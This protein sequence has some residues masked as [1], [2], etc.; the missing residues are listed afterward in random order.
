MGACRG[1]QRVGPPHRL[2]HEDIIAQPLWSLDPLTERVAPRGLAGRLDQRIERVAGYAERHRRPLRGEHERKRV[3]RSRP[4]DQLRI[5]EAEALFGWNE[6]VVNGNIVAAGAAQ[7]CRIP[8][9]KD[10]AL[11]EAQQ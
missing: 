7:P 11:A 9:V 3:E 2:L 8:G 4:L 6:L 1:Q 10:L 5:L